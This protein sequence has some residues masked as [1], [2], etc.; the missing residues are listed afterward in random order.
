MNSIC[1]VAGR[2]WTQVSNLR[3]SQQHV[4]RQLDVLISESAGGGGPTGL[5]SPET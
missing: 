2:E 5:L 4:S 3:R 1:T